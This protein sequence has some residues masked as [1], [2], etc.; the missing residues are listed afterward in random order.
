M[1]LSSTRRVIVAAVLVT[2]AV[3]LARPAAAAD[4]KEQP[5]VSFKNDIQPIFKES[6]VKCHSL[7]NPRKRAA[8]KLRLDKE[9]DAMKGGMSGKVII[10][11]DAEHSMLYQLLLGPVPDP[12]KSDEDIKAM[13]LP[14]K[15]G[16]EW[17]P[18]PKDQ[19]E[20]IKKWI[21]QGASWKS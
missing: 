21:D 15:K 13:P 9:K 12:D 10:P 17:K 16:M 11:G 20:L 14:P 5:K 7:N 4:Q 1:T 19:V 6:C 3:A 18:L 2:A 8:A